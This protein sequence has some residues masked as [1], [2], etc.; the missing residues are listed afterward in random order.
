MLP[1][2]YVQRRPPGQRMHRHFLDDLL[3]AHFM[4][5]FDRHR[6]VFQAELHERQ[7]TARFEGLG[8]RF[9]HLVRVRKFMINVDEK[10]QIARIRRQFGI[11]FR[12]EHGFDIGPF[13]P[14]RLLIDE[15][16]HFLLDVD[17]E[18]LSFLS[19]DLRQ[20]KRVIP[21][22]RADVGD[23]VSRLEPQRLVKQGWAF[24]FFALGAF[25]PSGR[26]VSHH[27]GDFATHV[28]L[29]STVRIVV[30][31][32]LILRLFRFGLIVGDGRTHD[33]DRRR[34]RQQP[35]HRSPFQ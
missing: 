32:K 6:R 35:N 21:A 8:H 31:A 16:E 22:P 27:Q 26:L 13:G 23:D 20:S 25:E 28:K 10:D 1:R 12:A 30:L 3:L 18:D 7:P 11:G 15:V 17:G 9:G 5:E 14:F 2:K 33:C 24:F 4:N 29:A 19:N 34:G